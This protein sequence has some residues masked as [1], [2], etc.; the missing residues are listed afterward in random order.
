MCYSINLVFGIL[1]FIILK[2]CRCSLSGLYFSGSS[3][4]QKIC[5]KV[6]WGQSFQIAQKKAK[7]FIYISTIIQVKQRRRQTTT[8][9]CSKDGED[10]TGVFRE[11]RLGSCTILYRFKCLHVN[12]ESCGNRIFIAN[13]TVSNKWLRNI[14]A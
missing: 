3:R 10:H 2:G 14:V 1:P 12:L 11:Y 4:I 5:R 13:K 6:F 8:Y 9:R 7:T